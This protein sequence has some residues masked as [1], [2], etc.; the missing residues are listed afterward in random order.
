[1]Y[2]KLVIV[3]S[4]QT[5]DIWLG[6]DDGHLVQRETGMLETMVMEGWSLQ[7]DDGGMTIWRTYQRL[8]VSKLAHFKYPA[9]VLIMNKE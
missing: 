3:A 1:V 6:D 2:R 7:D 5:T 8:C 9:S 4:S